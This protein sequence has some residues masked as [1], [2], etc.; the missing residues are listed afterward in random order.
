MPTGARSVTARLNYLAPEESTPAYYLYETRPGCVP[1]P[2]RVVK[3]AVTIESARGREHTLSLEQ[4]GF[5]ILRDPLPGLDFFDDSIVSERYYPQCAALVRAA[6]G[7]DR[8]LAFDH[9]VRDQ[10][11][12]GQPGSGIREPVRFVHN[13]YT[14]ASAPQ[15]VR[16]L[17]GAD[18]ESVLTGRYAFINVWRPLRGP[19][20]EQPLA[21]CDA[22][23]MQDEDFVAASL[24]YVDRRG[25][26]YSVRHSSRHRWLYLPEMQ[27]DEIWLLRCFDS[28]A[29]G[30]SRYTAHSAFR[31]PSTP[32]NAPPRR[33]I[34]VRTVALWGAADA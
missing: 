19:V 12:A 30:G 14:E 22:A 9:N 3:E 13:D 8:V 18:A 32:D 21:V 6:T 33:S 20:L 27:D 1:P 7:C 16:D 31:S 5:C 2:P 34:E 25:E 11:L 26:I 15:R 23:S 29:A 4:Q 28:D 24:N 10:S 17:C